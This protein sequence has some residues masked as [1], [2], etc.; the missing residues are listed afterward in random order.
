M[1]SKSHFIILGAILVLMIIVGSYALYEQE[2]NRIRTSKY[3]ELK[4]VADLKESQIL[5]W[6]KERNAEVK[7][8]TK[9]PALI[10]SVE[11]WL[12][13]PGNAL[14]KQEILERLQRFHH[15]F[16]YDDV[17]LASLGG[18]VLL[19]GDPKSENLD[20]FIGEKIHE[21]AQKNEI[22]LTDFY[23]DSSDNRIRIISFTR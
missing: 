18:D 14:Y 20:S 2:S 11:G 10:R 22:T 17:V 6:L 15:E 9:S 12:R 7:A 4:A 13:K 3:H 23:R 8:V 16:E 21:A 19:S 1:T 5:E